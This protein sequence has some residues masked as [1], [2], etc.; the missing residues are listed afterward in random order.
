[1]F[2]TQL[3]Q[4]NCVLCRWIFKRPA[5][6]VDDLPGDGAIQES[7]AEEDYGDEG[8]DYTSWRSLVVV[9]FLFIVSDFTYVNDFVGRRAK[10]Q[11]M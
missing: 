1:M 9:M 10:D 3:S 2:L 5:Y 7:Y 6:A 4:A 8:F 11:V